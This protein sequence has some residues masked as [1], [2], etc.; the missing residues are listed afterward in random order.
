MPWEGNSASHGQFARL[1]RY[2]R[3]PHSSAN[4][5]LT[6]NQGME[7]LI[8]QAFLHVDVIGQ[9]VQEGHYD[10]MGPDGEIVLPQVWERTVLPDW[11]ITMHMWPMPEPPKKVEKVLEIP[12]VGGPVHGFAPAP[13]HTVSYDMFGRPKKKKHS[14]SSSGAVI[15]PPPPMAPMVPGAG[16]PPPPL[17][18]VTMDPFVASATP[19]IEVLPEKS[20]K[21]RKPSQSI[22]PILS[23]AAG[24]GTRSRSRRW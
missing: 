8:K 4:C 24:G 1:G 14:K 17:G 2:H 7:E 23:W 9:H 13:A 5:L 18:V 16:I 22:P 3:L 20:D 10:L 12:I 11:L 19:G 6:P 15:I 21:R